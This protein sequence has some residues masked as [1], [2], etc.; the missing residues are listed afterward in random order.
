[1]VNLNL[2]IIYCSQFYSREIKQWYCISDWG[3]TLIAARA[4]GENGKRMHVRFP[5]MCYLFLRKCNRALPVLECFMFVLRSPT[6][7]KW[8]SIPIN[9]RY[10]CWNKNDERMTIAMRATDWVSDYKSTYYTRAVCH[11]RHERC[12]R[13][14]PSACVH[15]QRVVFKYS[16]IYKI[17]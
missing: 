10:N 13:L 2:F 8:T 5:A 11:Y 4:A 16:Q 7:C 12:Q 1:M 6:V 17:N 15:T 14:L 9:I 3:F